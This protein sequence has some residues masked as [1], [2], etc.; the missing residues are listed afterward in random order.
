MHHCKPNETCAIVMDMSWRNARLVYALFQYT[1]YL[2][3]NPM[4]LSQK[5]QAFMDS[6]EFE[7][8]VFCQT[9]ALSLIKVILKTAKALPTLE[10][11]EKFT[12]EESSYWALV[13]TGS[14]VWAGSM[15][16]AT[17]IY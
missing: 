1:P 16:R 2:H 10:K 6:K 8:E 11:M 14:R 15:G 9:V 7:Q 3:G 4:L 5:V 13:M 17:P 12:L